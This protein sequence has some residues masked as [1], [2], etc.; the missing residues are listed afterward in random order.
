MVRINNLVGGKKVP[1]T[2]Y[3]PPHATLVLLSLAGHFGA[4]CR[5]KREIEGVRKG[6]RK[7]GGS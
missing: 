4:R 2:T 3:H 5:E 7:S 6:A 1:A